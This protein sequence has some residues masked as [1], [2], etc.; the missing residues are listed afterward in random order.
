[1]ISIIRTFI[2]KTEYFMVYVFK[3]KKKKQKIIRKKRKKINQN[4]NMPYCFPLF[5]LRKFTSGG[6]I[7]IKCKCFTR[8]Q[9]KN[10]K[11]IKN[12]YISC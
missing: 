1:M 8:H 4:D 5:H 10:K 12:E 6:V 7:I 9:F 11:M 2:L 3:A